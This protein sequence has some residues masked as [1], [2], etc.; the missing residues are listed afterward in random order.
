MKRGVLSLVSK[1]LYL[2]F[3]WQKMISLTHLSRLSRLGMTIVMIVLLAVG[4]LAGAETARPAKTA[5]A[6]AG[7]QQK[8][9]ET[10]A[11]AKKEGKVTVYGEL[12]PAAR[13]GLSKAFKNRYGIEFEAVTGNDLEVVTKYIQETRNGVYLADVI[14]GGSPTLLNTLKSSVTLAPVSPNLILPE[15]KDPKAWPDGKIPFMDKDQLIV[16]STLGRNMFAIMN[17][18][19]VKE[20]EIASLQDFLNPK[21]KGQIAMFDPTVGGSTSAWF[22]LILTKVYGPVEGERY[23]RQLAQQEPI[24]IRDKR[25]PVEWV[26]KGKYPLHIGPNMQASV[27]FKKQGSPITGTKEKE[28]YLLHPS[29]SNFT[30][31]SKAP[32]PNAAT[33]LVNWLMTAEAGAILSQAWGAPASRLDVPAVGLDPMR[34]G[35]PGIKMYISDEEQVLQDPK[36]QEVCR[37]IFPK[38]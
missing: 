15:V 34:L 12:G 8:W 28:G 22:S 3:S 7:G 4:T 27:D 26:A 10:V 25:L 23:L 17:T 29:S 13:T 31:A 19:M 36:T 18:D 24:V 38:K 20:D 33:V 5:G 9:N 21:W 32:H 1:K 37:R 11:A 2:A 16:S 30:L 14:F 35:L 6:A